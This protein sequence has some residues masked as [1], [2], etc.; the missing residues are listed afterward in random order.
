MEGSTAAASN[1]GALVEHLPSLMSPQ[2]SVLQ[3]S[4]LDQ[5]PPFPFALSVV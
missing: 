1:K 2:S 4:T 3:L 5:T